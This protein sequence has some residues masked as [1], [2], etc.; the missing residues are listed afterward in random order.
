MWGR[1]QRLGGQAAQVEVV[2]PVRDSGTLRVGAWLSI[3]EVPTIARR[4]AVASRRVKMAGGTP[5]MALAHSLRMVPRSRK[6]AAVMM[7]VSM[8][9][10]VAAAVAIR[11][12]AR[13][14]ATPPHTHLF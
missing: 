13:A 9:A 8:S 1:S 3:G 7:A 5:R 6:R 4:T 14:Y 11:A 12:H 2:L 10:V